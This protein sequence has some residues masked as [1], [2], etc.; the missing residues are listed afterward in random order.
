MA[1]SALVALGLL[2]GACSSAE[3][4]LD[5]GPYSVPQNTIGKA[6]T[7]D[8]CSDPTGDVGADV[9]G[10]GGQSD[11][12]GIDLTNAQA[13]VVGDVLEVSFVTNG[14][15]EATTNPLFLIQQ[16]DTSQAINVSFELRATPDRAGRWGVNLITFSRGQQ[17]QPKP[18]QV[19]VT[20]Q[21]NQLSYTVPLASLPTIATIL[22]QF[23]A[24]AGVSNNNR[25]FDDCLPF[26]RAAQAPGTT[27]T[28]GEMSTT[29]ATTP[30]RTGR[31]G[32]LVEAQDGSKV[33]VELVDNP[34]R[35]T[36]QPRAEPIPQN[37]LAAIKAEV[38]AGTNGL[39]RVGDYRFTVQ[40]QDGRSFDPWAADDYTNEPRF[41]LETSLRAGECERGYINYEIPRDAK[42]TSV[43]YDV[44]GKKVGPYV[45][46]ENP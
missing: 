16:G 22:W 40:I 31:V 33:M 29:T 25:L 35:P 45:V 6:G 14:P 7:G 19:P 24:S 17:A 8:E 36:H 41:K 38:C 27:R 43:T 46:V 44:A 18:L 30:P 4:N 12:P 32:E 20:V 15:I 9:K 5:P 34:A 28:P 10:Q 1:V 26:T 13:K 2:L 42:I 23:G 3:E 21:G 11:P 39:D 37:Q